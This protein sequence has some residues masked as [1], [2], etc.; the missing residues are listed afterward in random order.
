M[1]VLGVI[2]SP[3]RQGN[4]AALVETVL[5]GARHSG[6]ETEAVY[7]GQI[8]LNPCLAC[9]SCKKTSRCVQQDD[10]HDVYD[11]I[12]GCRALVLGTPVYFDQVSAQAKMFIDRLYCYCYTD[13]GAVNFPPDYKGI[14]A[15][16]YE[17]AH[18]TRY[19]YVLDWMKERL[20]HYHRID[21]TAA[22]KASS[23]RRRPVSD[24]DA[25]LAHAY[26]EGRFLGEHVKAL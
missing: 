17:D 19:D 16:T 9:E 10:M 6:A 11:K 15:I 1:K 26:Q 25:L 7:L 20:E 24:N 18:P 23:T 4:T 2:G 22:L 3:R 14:V 5:E 21:V 12:A 8:N 13:R